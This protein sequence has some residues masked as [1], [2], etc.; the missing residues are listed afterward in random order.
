MRLVRLK[1]QSPGRDRGPYNDNFPPLW[2]PKF[3]ERKIAVSVNN[4]SKNR[5]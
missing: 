1:P 2:A 4:I 5:G 3:L